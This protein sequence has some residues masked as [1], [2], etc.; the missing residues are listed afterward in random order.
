MTKSAEELIGEIRGL[1]LGRV[2]QGRIE[3]IAEEVRAHLDAAVRARLELGMLPAEAEAEAVAAFGNPILVVNEL[4]SLH[5]AKSKTAFDRGVTRSL[6]CSLLGLCSF[7]C[8]VESR[9]RMGDWSLVL[10]VVLW[11]G[12]FAWIATESWRARRVQ[13]FPILTALGLGALLFAGLQSLNWSADAHASLSTGMLKSDVNANYGRAAT[14]FR[15]LNQDQKRFFENYNQFMSTYSSPNR[16]VVVPV[17]LAHGRVYRFDQTSRE[18]MLSVASDK[19]ELEYVSASSHEEAARNWA[20]AVPVAS[21]VFGIRH[22][23]TSSLAT[24]YGEQTE[25]SGWLNFVLFLPLGFF[26]SS[27]LMMYLGGAHLLAVLLRFV[28]SRR[29]RGPRLA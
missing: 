2:E 20:L 18:K 26:L 9:P 24:D 16:S 7:I 1:S 27:A 14:D 21:E 22:S 23:I 29:S 3:E 8:F 12:A 19:A 28:W 17:V 11:L 6:F 15:T 25:R 13:V 10:Y 5:P 4:A